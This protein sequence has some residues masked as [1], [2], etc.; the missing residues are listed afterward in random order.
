MV[1]YSVFES[2]G[3]KVKVLPVLETWKFDESE[4]ETVGKNFW[5][6]KKCNSQI[7]GDEELDE[8]SI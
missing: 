8:V 7:E 4:V 3:I 6:Y 2:L 5:E 1:V